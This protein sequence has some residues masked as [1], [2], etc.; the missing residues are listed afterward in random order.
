MAMPLALVNGLLDQRPRTEHLAVTIHHSPCQKH[1]STIGVHRLTFHVRIR[2]PSITHAAVPTPYLR[3]PSRHHLGASMSTTATKHRQAPPG[4]ASCKQVRL[5]DWAPTQAIRAS[6]RQEHTVT[7][8]LPTPTLDGC[9]PRQLQSACVFTLWRW[10]LRV[11]HARGTVT[12]RG[13]VSSILN[14]FLNKCSTFG[15]MRSMCSRASQWQPVMISIPHYI[16][17]WYW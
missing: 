11:G 2:A 3:P 8:G 5:D 1:H 10:Q 14:K 17:H 15:S 16:R 6:L 12:T 13:T 4:A 7:I 9:L